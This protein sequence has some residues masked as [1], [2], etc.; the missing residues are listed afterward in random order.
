MRSTGKSMNTIW[1][2]VRASSSVPA[3]SISIPP[4]KKIRGNMSGWNLTG[5]GCRNFCCG[6]GWNRISP[7]IFREAPR[8]GNDYYIHEAVVYIQQ[9]YHREITVDEVAAF[10]RLNRV[11]F[12]RRFKERQGCTPQEFIIRQ[13][14]TNAAE[15]LRSTSLPVKDVADRCGYKNQLYFSQAFRKYYGLPPR[16]WRRQNCEKKD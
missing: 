12:S 3:R 4:M 8:R 1:E 9:N 14:L 15:L 13:R 2:P 16:E 6:Q 5:C 7:S 11:Y 10:C